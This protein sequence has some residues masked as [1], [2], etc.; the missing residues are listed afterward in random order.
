M[1]Q[2]AF[3]LDRHAEDALLTG[4]LDAGHAVLARVQTA[5]ELA[6]VLA[7]HR[8]DI[9]VV[10]AAPLR[11]TPELRQAAASAGTRLVAIA[12][13]D[14]A[15][16]LA[17]G[18]GVADV[19]PQP[20]D[21]PEFE[22][23]LET[24][25]APTGGGDGPGGEAS[26]IVVWGP[27][28][29]PGRTSLAVSIAAELALTGAHVALVDADS[30]GGSVAPWLGLLDEAPGF[31]A[32][33]RLAGA[34]QLT[35]VEID[36]V[37]QYV[38]TPRGALAVLTG[39]ARASR[40]PELGQDRVGRVLA[41][42]AG[43]FQHV[44]VD[45]GFNLEA[46]EEIASDLFA[47]RRNAATLAA[48]EAATQLVCVGAADPVGLSRLLRCQPEAARLAAG[49]RSHVVVN[50]VREGVVGARPEAQIAAALERFGGMVPAA[51]VPEDQ[52]AFDLAMR[53]A[54]PLAAVAPRSAARLA[55]RQLVTGPILGVEEPAPGRRRTRPARR[56]RPRPAPDPAAG[57]ALDWQGVHPQ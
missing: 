42:L 7:A 3:C 16:A 15:R 34:G 13:D 38:P 18:A 51:L 50:R 20:A 2:L 17:R 25:A 52:P 11:I 28:G 30:Y 19:V 27:T 43:W 39:I 57:A 26:V 40:W 21:W 29:A 14:E 49:A 31:A 8:V 12:A 35:R 36:R 45:V 23:M 46:D 53:T 5:G 41:A 10:T 47:P 55:V 44:V 33:C 1:A 56:G 4:A 24:P 9:A 22:R 48:L 54:Q 37:A 6:G 32:A